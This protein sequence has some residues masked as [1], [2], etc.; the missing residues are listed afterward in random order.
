LYTCQKENKKISG[1]YCIQNKVNG[2]KLVGQSV[3]ISKRWKNGH[4]SLLENNKHYNK[5]FQNSWN[6]YGEENFEFKILEI[7]ENKKEIL[8]EKEKYWIE[9][10]E[11]YTDPN[12]GFNKTP[13]GGGTSGNNS[14]GH[15]IK[16]KKFEEIYGE[17]RAKEIKEEISIVTSGKNNP[18]YGRDRSGELNPMYGKNHTEE[19]KKH[20]K[21]TIKKNGG[22]AGEKNGMFGK[23][24]EKFECPWCYIMCSKHI[25]KRY[26]GNNCLKKPGNEHNKRIG[27]N[28]GKHIKVYKQS[29]NFCNRLISRANIKSHENKCKKK[30][31]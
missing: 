3:N 13:G 8:D 10:Y 29:C 16:G 27:P 22:H 18:M 24:H 23:H 28:L 30:F 12:R 14:F 15:K 9:F 1:I 5:H 20:M 2:K 4:L 7:C 11:T 17:E 21:D 31:I 25:M 6:K 26:H 19:S